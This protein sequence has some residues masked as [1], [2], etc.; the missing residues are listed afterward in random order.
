M[1]FSTALTYLPVVEKDG[2]GWCRVFMSM[3]DWAAFSRSAE[4]RTNTSPRRAMYL[5]WVVSDG[6]LG[7]A[8][9]YGTPALS[10]SAS[11]ALMPEFRLIA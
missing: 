11:I 7:I 4:D 8:G 1:T 10:E 5:A 3:D 6:G 2:P 9:A